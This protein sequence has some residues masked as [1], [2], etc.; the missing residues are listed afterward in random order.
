MNLIY[1]GLIT[2]RVPVLPVFLPSHYMLNSYGDEHSPL[3]F[4]DVFDLSHL[5]KAIKKPVLE[6]RDIKVRLSS[7][8]SILL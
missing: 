6:W 3:P 1:L 2:D 7:V 8:V 5:R 4:G